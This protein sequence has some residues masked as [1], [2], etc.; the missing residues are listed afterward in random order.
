MSLHHCIIIVSSSKNRSLYI[1]R[2]RYCYL[3]P[4]LQRFGLFNAKGIQRYSKYAKVFGIQSFYWSIFR[5]SRSEEF[6]GICILKNFLKFA[7]NPCYGVLC[8]YM[9]WP[10]IRLKKESSTRIFQG[11][12]WFSSKQTYC[13]PTVRRCFVNFK[14][15]KSRFQSLREQSRPVFSRFLSAFETIILKV[16]HRFSFFQQIQQAQ[17]YLSRYEKDS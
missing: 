13:S 3:V 5:N 1:L 12:F 9:L 16:H 17:T 7:S 6:C 8:L 14:T 2:N 10:F 4:K 15:S 11:Y